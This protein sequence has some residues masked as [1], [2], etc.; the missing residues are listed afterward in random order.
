MNKKFCA[1]VAAAVWVE[2]AY[3]GAAQSAGITFIGKG[4]IP[5]T[6]LDDS[7][8][9]YLLEDGLTPANLVGGLG[10]AI[11][12]SGTGDVFYATPDRGPAEGTTTYIDR[13]IS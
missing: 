2:V 4:S 1:A 12:Y 5:G 6:A 8:L 11:T 13:S 7:G 10:S 9:G 3:V